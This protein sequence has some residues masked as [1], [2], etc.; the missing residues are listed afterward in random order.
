MIKLLDSTGVI[1][2][3]AVI[4]VVL[5]LV[6]AILGWA[7]S[8]YNKLVKARNRVDNSWAQIDVQLKTRFDLIPNLVETVKGFTKHESEI[9]TSFAD[10]RKMYDS[11]KSSGSVKSLAEA[12]ASLSRALNIAVNAVQE[13]YPQIQANAQYQQLIGSLKDCEN[14]IAYNRQFYNDTV[15][16]YNN[17]RQLFPSSII[18]SMFHF[19]G[20]EYFKVDIEEQRE[21]PKVSF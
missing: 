13:Q 8:A 20:K 17:L 14:K 7:I 11:A 16:S 10:A 19:E 9:L 21:A 2:A 6:F 15:L 12:D 18:A 4:V 3:V 1:I 5:V